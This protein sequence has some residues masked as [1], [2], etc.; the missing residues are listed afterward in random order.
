MI[1]HDDGTSSNDDRLGAIGD[2]RFVIEQAGL[3][4][5]TCS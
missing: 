3:A 1:V 5:T 4:T 2:I